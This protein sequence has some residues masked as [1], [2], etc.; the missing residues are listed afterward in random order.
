MNTSL[1]APTE[2][3]EILNS[4]F[5]PAD[6]RSNEPI[7]YMQFSDIM[8]ILREESNNNYLK[9]FPL[10]TAMRKYGFQTRSVKMRRFAMQPR[11][12][13]PVQLINYTEGMKDRLYQYR[14]E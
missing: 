9:I 4:V 8:R 5:K 7:F 10:Q 14:K 13:Y 1:E 6:E 2:E 12:L 11:N 3:A